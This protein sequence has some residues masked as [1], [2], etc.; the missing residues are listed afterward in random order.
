MSL[1]NTVVF[2]FSSLRC[3]PS[4][5]LAHGGA[6]SGGI[7]RL[8]HEVWKLCCLTPQRGGGLKT[9]EC[10]TSLCAQGRQDCLILLQ[11]SSAG[12]LPLILGCSIGLSMPGY[13]RLET[14]LLC[15]SSTLLSISTKH[16]AFD[17]FA[18]GETCLLHGI[19]SPP[20]SA[21]HGSLRICHCRATSAITALLRQG[22][23]VLLV[24]SRRIC[25]WCYFF[26]SI[27][28]VL[29]RFQIAFGTL[30][31]YPCCCCLFNLSCHAG[32]SNASVSTCCHERSIACSGG[33]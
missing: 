18:A 13:S 33:L 4:A 3:K 29:H 21:G 31:S 15:S 20:L 24:L 11:D 30:S 14:S 10:C 1:P 6:C 8:V 19:H 9:I 25:H 32:P 16:A 5:L 26:A 2:C 28:S 23:E 17:M 22:L 12:S 7:E 27:T